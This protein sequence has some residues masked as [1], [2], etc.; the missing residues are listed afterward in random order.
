M[1][2]TRLRKLRPLSK[3]T[4]VERLHHKLWPLFSSYVR[5]KAKGKCF[6]CGSIHH[7]KECD[8]SHFIH[9]RLDYSD[10][11]IQCCCRKCNRFLHGNLGRYAEELIRTYGGNVLMELRQESA[12]IKKWEPWELEAIIKE[13]EEKLE[14]L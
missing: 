6:C 10:R 12:K 5:Q 9:R 1:K 4:L 13:T 8:A 7:W 14:K 2:R 11:N 3:K